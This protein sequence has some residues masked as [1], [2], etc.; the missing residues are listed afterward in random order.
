M[1]SI[2]KQPKSTAPTYCQNIPLG[3][4]ITAKAN[5]WTSKDEKTGYTSGIYLFSK[6]LQIQSPWFYCKSGTYTANES[7]KPSVSVQINEPVHFG[8]NI[9]KAN[10]NSDHT[11]KYIVF[12][13][14]LQHHVI[15]K[16]REQLHCTYGLVTG[17]DMA[18]SGMYKF[19]YDD[20]HSDEMRFTCNKDTMILGRTR[21]L[22][23]FTGDDSDIGM[24]G[25]YVY[26]Q[27]PSVPPCSTVK[28]LFTVVSIHLID[29]KF[30]FSLC[31]NVILVEQS[32]LQVKRIPGFKREPA[33]SA[34]AVIPQKPTVFGIKKEPVSST[35]G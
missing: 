27:L 17:A 12:I 7:A 3:D 28:I 9:N 8:N 32:H 35:F 26:T 13:D 5:Q 1:A 10:R 25:D 11:Q 19:G 20:N 22:K 18:V 4:V 24:P 2:T 6:S 23:V 31:P 34:V 21:K 16:F 15:Q 33:S 14:S 29:N 30:I